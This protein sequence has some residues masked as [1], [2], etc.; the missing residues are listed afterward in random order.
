L[1]GLIAS[2]VP[3]QKKKIIRMGI[4]I[5]IHFFDDNGNIKRI[6]YAKFNRIYEKESDEALPRYAGKRV[7]CSI[8]FVE[9]KDRKPTWIRHSDYTIIPLNLEGRV[10]EEEL[11]RASRLG[12]GMLDFI[13]LRQADNV[14]NISPHISKKLYHEEFSWV[15]GADQIEAI[16]KDVFG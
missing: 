13:D 8:S 10:D 16:V 9:F 1:K 12:V 5:R 15:P 4:G 2:T 11:E 3:Y 6:P 7:K 14:L